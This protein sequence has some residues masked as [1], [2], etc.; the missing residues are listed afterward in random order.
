[1]INIDSKIATII[2][3]ALPVLGVL[4]SGGL[5]E[6]F[7]RKVLLLVGLTAMT[8]SL[9]TLGIYFHLQNIDPTYVINIKFVPI[10]SLGVFVTFFSI[11][12]GPIA[13]VLHGEMFS[14]PAKVYAAAFGQ[15]INFFLAFVLAIAFVKL[16]QTVGDGPTFYFFAVIAILSV[17]F[18]KMFVVETKG[19]TLMEIQE[20]LKF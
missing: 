12:I 15:V 6:K 7:G 5:L 8:L 2:V 18:V 11:G 3:G 9:L 17:L 10:L 13:Y 14:S 4:M 1:M 19:K 16:R 20:M